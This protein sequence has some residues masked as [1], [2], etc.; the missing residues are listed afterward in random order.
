MIYLSHQ[1]F[2]PLFEGHDALDQG[3][4]PPL[5]YDRQQRGIIDYFNA[6][7]DV[8]DRDNLTKLSN[9]MH[10]K[11]ACP[12]CFLPYVYDAL[13]GERDKRNGG[14]KPKHTMMERI[15]I[16]LH[17]RNIK[18][19][20]PHQSIDRIASDLA[21]SNYLGSNET[22]NYYDDLWKEFS[23]N[24]EVNDFFGRLTTGG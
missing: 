20:N 16:Y 13:S 5:S 14:R 6:L 3:S 21:E 11:I 22:K 10:S 9:L 1:L 24:K 8:Y 18:S 12:P 4:L 17:I 19:D 2:T 23:A 7:S 15:N